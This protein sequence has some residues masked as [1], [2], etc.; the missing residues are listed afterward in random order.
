L[1]DATP[2]KNILKEGEPGPAPSIIAPLFFAESRK[3]HSPP[4]YIVLDST[5]IK[6]A[7]QVEPRVPRPPKILAPIFS[8]TAR[9]RTLSKGS[10]VQHL[11]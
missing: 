5:P 11:E 3:G 1:L 6:S 10:R 9:K 7:Q 8:V 4:E 2:I